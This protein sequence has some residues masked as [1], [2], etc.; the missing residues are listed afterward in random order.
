MFV[1]ADRSWKGGGCWGEFE[2]ICTI[3][4]CYSVGIVCK[5]Y[6]MVGPHNPISYMGKNN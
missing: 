6:V 3:Y 4:F 2:S 1:S 5:L